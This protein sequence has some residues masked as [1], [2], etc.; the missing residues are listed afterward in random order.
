MRRLL[1]FIFCLSCI[2]ACGDE[3]F[4]G[5]GGKNPLSDI[6][7]SKDAACGE[8]VVIQWNGV[9]QSAKVFLVDEAG[10]RYEAQVKVVTA[11]GMI[12]LVPLGL[13]PGDYRV[14]LVQQEEIEAGT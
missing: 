4:N 7:L 6:V 3:V 2:C 14:I 8:E 13:T 5:G 12:F 9:L 11:S 1:L 10:Q